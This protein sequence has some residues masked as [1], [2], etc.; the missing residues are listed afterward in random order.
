MQAPKRSAF[1]SLIKDHLNLGHCR[2]SENDVATISSASVC[3]ASSLVGDLWHMMAV[4]TIQP[5]HPVHL[6]KCQTL[7]ADQDQLYPRC[8]LAG[9][10]SCWLREFAPN[11]R[12]INWANLIALPVLRLGS[13]KS[14]RA[15]SKKISSNASVCRHATFHKKRA[16]KRPA[17]FHCLAKIVN[18]TIEP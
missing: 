14:E 11:P 5:V 12:C 9:I 17:S 10:Y 4:R 6:H 7:P 15:P 8:G 16:T 1:T 18:R 13:R 3:C 2:V